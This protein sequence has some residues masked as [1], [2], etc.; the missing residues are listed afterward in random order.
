MSEKDIES[1]LHEERAFPPPAGF[2]DHAR[3][4]PSEA[5]TLRAAAAADHVGFW[6]DLARRS[7]HWHRPFTVAL[8]DSRAPNYRWFTDG[9]L[10]VAWNCLDVHLESR[11]DQPAIVFEGEAGEVRRFS[12]GELHAEV[13]RLANGLKALKW[14]RRSSRDHADGAGGRH[15]DA[16]LRIS[17]APGV[18]ASPSTPADRARRARVC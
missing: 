2:A 11:A 15:C 18:R 12:Y 4:G 16:G 13:C 7:L 1:A 6:A 8:D 14:A 9:E 3:I 5:A 10:N 17:A